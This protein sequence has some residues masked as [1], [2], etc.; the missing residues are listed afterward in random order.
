MERIKIVLIDDKQN[1]LDSFQ[2]KYDGEQ[3]QIY[4]FKSL[5]E[6]LPIIDE[7]FYSFHFIILDGKGFLKKDETGHGSGKFALKSREEIEELIRRKG[8]DLPYCYHTAYSGED[9][10]QALSDST[11]GYTKEA[12]RIFNKLIDE[13]EARMFKYIHERYEKLEEVTIKRNY[14]D[15]F[16]IFEMGLLDNNTEREL[17][18][19]IKLLKDLTDDNSKQFARNIR[20]LMEAVFYKL[21]EI[22]RKYL[23][24]NFKKSNQ[25]S[26]TNLMKFLAGTPTWSDTDRIVKPITEVHLPAHLYELTLGIQKSSSASAMH[27]Y[28]NS[29]NRYTAISYLNGLFDLLIWF[30][31]IGENYI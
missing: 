6:A 8:R 7:H 13:D 5:E 3:Y 31:K 14:S 12:I 16:E 18:N 4:C 19:T 27:E 25:Q 20:P 17:I 1:I 23:P 24:P 30:K 10:M 11:Y 29:I 22:D 9:I 15:V 26:L 21:I 28:S 2:N